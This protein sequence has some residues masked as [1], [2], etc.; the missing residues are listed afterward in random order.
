M[1]RGG[2]S[3]GTGVAIAAGYCVAGLGSDTGCSIRAP[4]SINCLVGLRPTHGL[5]DF[6][7]VMPMNADWDTVGPMAR[8]VTDLAR[9]LDVI[10]NGGEN[11]SPKPHTGAL[12]TASLSETRVGVLRQLA[13]PR[14]TDGGVIGLLDQAVADFEKGGATVIERNSDGRVCRSLRFRRLVHAVSPRH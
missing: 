1:P 9:V 12:N 10:T 11:D 5:I 13:A 7:G 3:G 4:S 2:S 14:E 6:K 8:N